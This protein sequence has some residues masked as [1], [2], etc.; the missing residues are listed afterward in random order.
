MKYK[1]KSM[2]PSRVKQ[3]K[4]HK[5]RLDKWRYYNVIMP[6]KIVNSQEKQVL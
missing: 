5:K 3:L 4:K 6:N 1:G 2:K